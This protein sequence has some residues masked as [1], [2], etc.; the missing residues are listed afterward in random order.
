[1]PW[2]QML[3][4]KEASCSFTT[5]PRFL[6]CLLLFQAEQLRLI[7]RTDACT[8]R[9][10]S[11]EAYNALITSADYRKHRP[12]HI[13]GILKTFGLLLEPFTFMLQPQE[14]EVLRAAFEAQC[15]EP[16]LR[17]EEKFRTSS[18]NGFRIHRE[19]YV[20][21]FNALSRQFYEDFRA[22]KLDCKNVLEARRKISVAKIQPLSTDTKLRAE[23]H[24][25]LATMPGLTIYT[26]SRDGSSPNV[27]T[28]VK[29]EALV[30]WGSEEKRTEYAQVREDS[31]FRAV[32][33]WL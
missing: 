2:R 26:V 20:T 28:L 22:D 12:Q 21:S 16:A 5:N 31:F 23:L 33:S 10:W 24:C 9:N 15:I 8:V 3:N 6:S 14:G 13:R 27:Q 1:M 25:V 19:T 18:T 17:L 7:L 29:Q 30:A 4:P 32:C 11:A